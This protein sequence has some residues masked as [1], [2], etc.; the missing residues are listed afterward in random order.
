M[1]RSEQL[2]SGPGPG[3]DLDLDLVWTW[4]PD[5]IQLQLEDIQTVHVFGSLMRNKVNKWNIFVNEA[6]AFLKSKC[7]LTLKVFKGLNEIFRC[8]K[9]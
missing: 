4:S 7:F 2:R 3:L 5:E 9:L 8:F 1:C 6:A